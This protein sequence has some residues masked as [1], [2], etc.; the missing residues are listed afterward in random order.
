MQ[1]GVYEAE[2]INPKV[3]QQHVSP[4]AGWKDDLILVNEQDQIIQSG[5]YHYLSIKV[6]PIDEKSSHRKPSSTSDCAETSL[7]RL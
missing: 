1:H 2:W 6:V 5:N 3:S 7:T 4:E